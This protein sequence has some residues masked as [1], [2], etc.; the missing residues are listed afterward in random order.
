M[1]NRLLVWARAHVFAELNDLSLFTHGWK[2]FRLGPLLRGERTKRLYGSFFSVKTCK[3]KYALKSKKSIVFEPPIEKLKE[4]N[5]NQT[6]VFNTLPSKKDYFESL[7]VHRGIV[8]QGFYDMVANEIHDQIKAYETFTIGI[9]IRLGDFKVGKL[10]TDLS[11]YK[12]IAI[13]LNEYYNSKVNL[14][15]FSDGHQEELAEMLELPNTTIFQSGNDL[16]DLIQLSKCNVIVA[17]PLSTYSYWAGFI[18]EA[19]IVLPEDYDNGRIRSKEIGSFEGSIQ[20]FL[21]FKKLS[22]KMTGQIN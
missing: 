12:N 9:H 15:I 2:N 1:C 17:A 16:V 4:S 13:Q 19:D 10:N 5:T 11:Y 14:V 21:T 8:K 7:R 3:F 6:F 18:S 22:A 20:G